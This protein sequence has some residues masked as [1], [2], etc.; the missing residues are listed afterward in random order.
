VSTSELPFV[1]A[2]AATGEKWLRAL[3][4]EVGVP[5]PTEHEPT[6][7]LALASTSPRVAAPISCWLGARGDMTAVEALA[8]A[9]RL[10]E[11]TGETGLMRRRRARALM[12]V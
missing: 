10:T 9:P 3:A 5:V 12:R 2:A 7:M 8:V 11:K 4:T 1:P 6:D